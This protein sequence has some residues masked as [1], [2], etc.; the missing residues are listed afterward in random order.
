MAHSEVLPACATAQKSSVNS[1]V[2]QDALGRVTAGLS[3]CGPVEN[4]TWSSGCS[5][6]APRM[7]S[8]GSQSVARAGFSFSLNSVH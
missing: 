5:P 4:H 8:L 2:E 1:E 6:E 3:S 7:N